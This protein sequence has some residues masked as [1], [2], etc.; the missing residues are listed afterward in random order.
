[1]KKIYNIREVIRIVDDD[2]YDLGNTIQECNRKFKIIW[3]LHIYSC[4]NIDFF[5]AK[6]N[7]V[8]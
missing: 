4:H 2:V 1:M 6:V 8:P 5:G 7:A 3:P